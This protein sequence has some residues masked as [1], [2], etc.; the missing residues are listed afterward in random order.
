MQLTQIG[1]ILCMR[2]MPNLNG[3]ETTGHNSTEVDS[4]LTF[5]F[6]FKLFSVTSFFMVTRS[7]SFLPDFFFK[8]VLS[9]CSYN[10]AV[11]GTSPLSN[12]RFITTLNEYFT[13]PSAS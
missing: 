5:V 13:R 1:S 3:K 9:K 6:H 7:K 12:T 2:S 4:G 11:I 10:K 8:G